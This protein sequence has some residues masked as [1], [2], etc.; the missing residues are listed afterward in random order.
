M[1][2]SA[3]RPADSLTAAFFPEGIDGKAF[4]TRLET[5]FGVKLAGGQGRWKGKILRIAHFGTID[6]LDILSALAAMELVLVEMGR[7]VKLGSGVAAASEVLARG[8]QADRSV[9]TICP[10]GL[11][12][13]DL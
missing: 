7:S 2:L 9:E 11:P 8:L 5:R 6:E 10:V 3:A 4:L 1:R 13:T 12:T